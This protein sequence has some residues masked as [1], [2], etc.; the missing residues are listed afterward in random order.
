MQ[1]AARLEA[2]GQLGDQRRLNQAAFIV[3]GLVPGVGEKDVCAVQAV[4]WQH[5]VNHL[6]RVVLQDANIGKRLLGDA[7]EQRAHAGRVHFAAQKIVL[8]P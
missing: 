1:V 2:G 6:D 4:K 3:L 8:R 7:L 5:V